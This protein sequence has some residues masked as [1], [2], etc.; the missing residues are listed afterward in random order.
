MLHEPTLYW[1]QASA[2]N[3]AWLPEERES[4]PTDTLARITSCCSELIREWV[5]KYLC[6]GLWWSRANTLPSYMIG[7]LCHPTI[8]NNTC[9]LA[10]ASSLFLELPCFKKFAFLASSIIVLDCHLHW[11]Y[12]RGNHKPH[13]KFQSFRLFVPLGLSDV[14]VTRGNSL[15]EVSLQII[16]V[17]PPTVSTLHCF[18][19][20]SCV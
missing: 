15:I 10:S 18:M 5:Q 4:Q 11:L 1:S 8:P 20:A 2:S 7:F 16:T 3:Y 9:C 12:I 17:A 19:H 6:P 14:C 13:N